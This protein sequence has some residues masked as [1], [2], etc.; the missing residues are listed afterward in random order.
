[1]HRRVTLQQFGCARVLV[2]VETLGGEQ[3]I[4]VCRCEAT[5]VGFAAQCYRTGRSALAFKRAGPDAQPVPGALIHGLWH[6]YATELAAAD[7]SVYT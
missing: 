1:M 5:A 6:T 2:A 4:D 7:V 3:S